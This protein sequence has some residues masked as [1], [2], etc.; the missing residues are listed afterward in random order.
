MIKLITAPTEPV[1]E[2]V[3]D[4]ELPELVL[5]LKYS[6]TEAIVVVLARTCLPLSRFDSAWVFCGGG[7]LLTFWI[8][9]LLS[10]VA[11]GVGGTVSWGPGITIAG[12]D[13]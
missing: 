6:G 3:E 8:F 10:S 5:K 12:D 2:I 13:E 1:D 7:L 4:A 11:T 9:G